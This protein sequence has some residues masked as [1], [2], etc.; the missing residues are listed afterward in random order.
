[1]ERIPIRYQ[2]KMHNI[3]E[4][5]HT[6][7]NILST[8]CRITSTIQLENKKTVRIRKTTSPDTN[9]LEIYKALGIETH[10]CKTEKAYF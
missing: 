5:W 3:N 9:Q 8:Q 7:R 2:L 6:L 10:P 4:G 1:M